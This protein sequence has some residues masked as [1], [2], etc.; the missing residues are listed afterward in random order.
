MSSPDN[1][2]SAPLH[3]TWPAYRRHGCRCP[4]IV[5]RVRASRRTHRRPIF[6]DPIAVERTIAGEPLPLNLA[7]RREAIA[8]LDAA[9]LSASAIAAKLG[10]AERTVVRHRAARRADAA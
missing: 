8:R 6:I 2:C 5:Q 7:E 9:R 10:I 3:G 1:A 4:D